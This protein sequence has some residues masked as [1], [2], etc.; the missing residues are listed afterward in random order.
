[1]GL[2]DVTALSQRLARAEAEVA[3]LTTAEREARRKM[4]TRSKIVVGAAVLAAAR[5]DPAFRVALVAVLRGAELSV[6]D[7]A[8]VASELGEGWHHDA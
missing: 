1:M 2:R 7:T 4:Q 6:R 8:D 3:R 5:R